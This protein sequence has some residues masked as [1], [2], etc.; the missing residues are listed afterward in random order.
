MSG[1]SSVS[2]STRLAAISPTM[3]CV[4]AVLHKLLPAEREGLASRRDGPSTQTCDRAFR[5]GPRTREGGQ[6]T[7]V[8]PSASASTGCGYPTRWIGPTPWPLLRVIAAA[9]EDWSP[10]AP[11]K[12][13]AVSPG[14]PLSACVT[15]ASH[16]AKR[17]QKS[18]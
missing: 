7:Q 15:S 13:R 11:L 10:H 1:A 5:E 3:V 6:G 12:V 18:P 4:F 14:R 16:I 17:E 9:P 2:R 8:A